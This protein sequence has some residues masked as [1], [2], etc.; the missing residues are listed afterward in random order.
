[1]SHIEGLDNILTNLQKAVQTETAKMNSRVELAGDVL[2]DAVRAQASLTDHSLK[3]LA[4]LG[5]PYSKRYPVDH[6]PHGDDTLVHI[7]SGTLYNNIEKQSDIGTMRSSVAVGVS[8]S[9]VPYIED[10][11]VGA[12]RARPR[13]FIQRA[14]AEVDLDAVMDGKGRK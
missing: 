6:N 11:M 2:Y 9:K 3:D 13:R 12:P 4:R 5:F 7:Q 14:Y 1:M 8:P 10:L